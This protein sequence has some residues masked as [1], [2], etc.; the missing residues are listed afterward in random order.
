MPKILGAAS[1]FVTTISNGVALS[2]ILRNRVSVAF[3]TTP[4]IS[5]GILAL[6]ERRGTVPR[7]GVHLNSQRF[8]FLTERVNTA[9]AGFLIYRNMRR[10]CP[11]L[12]LRKVQFQS[13][14]FIPKQWF[15]GPLPL[16]R[17]NPDSSALVI[18]SLARATLSLTENPHAR[19]H[20]M[21]DERVQPVP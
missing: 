13:R 15:R 12:S 3:V 2:A 5:I 8:G 20:A 10:F 9:S 1:V 19:P 14:L 7:D 18:Y 21:A 16:P 6:G 17:F 4:I 11:A